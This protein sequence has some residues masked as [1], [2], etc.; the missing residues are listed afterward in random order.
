MEKSKVKFA[1]VE[2]DKI[3]PS[4]T[5]PAKFDRLLK[6]YDLKNLVNGKI[7]ALKMHLGRELGYTTIHPLFVKILIK[8]IREAG[9]E[10]FITDILLQHA[11]DFGGMTAHDRYTE[12]ML[13]APIYPVAGVYDKYFYSKKVNFKT[14]KEI[15]VA[16]H[17]HDAEVMIDFSH[18]KGHG[19]SSFGGAIKNIAMGCVTSETRKNIHALHSTGSGIIWDENLCDHCN[20]CIDECRYKANKFDENNKYFV[21]LHDCTYCQHCIEIC[22]NHALSLESKNYLDFLE[23]LIIATNEVLKTFL[24]DKVL[25]INFLMNMTFMCDCWG[26][27]TPSLV[28]DIGI[29]SSYDIVAIEKASLDMIKS[30]D[31]LPNSLPKGRE[32]VN[33][34]HLFERVWG[35][36]PYQ[37][38]ELAAK[39]NLGNKN[40]EIEEIF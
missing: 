35:K 27:S 39:I 24:P 6:S 13:G 8:N 4:A 36:D 23:G 16:G 28:P 37:Q 12:E 38:V 9:G 18:F 32:L 29:L 2:F 14:L 22:P 11:K 19:V 15:Q 7:V 25:Y 20:K 21:V 17:I 26:M 3:D 33:G 40:Y 34:N 10:V 1:S 5:L 31:V 30:L